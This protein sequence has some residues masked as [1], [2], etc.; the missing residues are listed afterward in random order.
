MMLMNVDSGPVGPLV[1]TLAN[2]ASH[3]RG[4]NLQFPR[5]IGPLANWVPANRAP[6]KL[7][8]GQLDPCGLVCPKMKVQISNLQDVFFSLVPPLKVPST[9]KVILARL[10]VSRPIYVNVDSPTLGFLYF[11]FLGGYQL[12]KIPCMLYFA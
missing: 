8:A 2:W 6:G 9:K 1:S 10:G 11:N 3:F 12:K 7:V 5:Q 4:P